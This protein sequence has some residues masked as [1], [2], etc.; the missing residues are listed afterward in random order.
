MKWK[1]WKQTQM[2]DWI[3]MPCNITWI[4]NTC[5]QRQPLVSHITWLS[6][7]WHIFTAHTADHLPTWLPLCLPLHPGTNRYWCV[8]CLLPSCSLSFILDRSVISA[9]IA[10][11]SCGELTGFG[12]VSMNV[13]AG[14]SVTNVAVCWASHALIVHY[15]G[16]ACT[17]SLM[18]G[19]AACAYVALQVISPA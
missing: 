11:V 10:V 12:V 9:I 7:V 5:S 16:C 1:H 3:W 4:Y 6:A 19:Q 14:R 15:R 18:S 17:Q 2:W 8:P 13:C